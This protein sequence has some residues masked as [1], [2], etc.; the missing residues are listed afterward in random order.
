[1][2]LNDFEIKTLS[3]LA[4]RIGLDLTTTSFEVL[5]GDSFF[6][7]CKVSKGS[8]SENKFGG[9]SMPIFKATAPLDPIVT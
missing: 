2:P 1:L 8:N 9:G 3:A 6:Y 5:G 7:I 4:R